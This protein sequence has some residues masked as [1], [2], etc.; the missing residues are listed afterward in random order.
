LSSLKTVDRLD[1][2]PKVESSV[3]FDFLLE[4]FHFARSI[5]FHFAR[6]KRAL[7][8]NFR[9]IAVPALDLCFVGGS[10][11]STEIFGIEVL[12]GDDFGDDDFDSSHGCPLLYF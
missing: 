7:E 11:V 8:K 12:L 6:L 2:V 10:F 4:Q 9:R 1:H 3:V 5:L